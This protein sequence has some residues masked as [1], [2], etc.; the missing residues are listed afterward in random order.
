MAWSA[1]TASST[2]PEATAETL[3]LP[4]TTPP[5]PVAQEALAASQEER[6][7]ADIPYLLRLLLEQAGRPLRGEQLVAAAERSRDGDELHAARQA[8]RAQREKKKAAQAKAAALAALVHLGE[9]YTDRTNPFG[10][11]ST[12]GLHL[13]G[14]GVH[15]P[16][17]ALRALPGLGAR[18]GA[19]D[20]RQSYRAYDFTPCSAFGGQQAA[21]WN[22]F[23]WGTGSPGCGAAG[24]APVAV[25]QRAL[26][27]RLGSD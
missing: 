22:G 26:F 7:A 5:D 24:L 3:P 14:S 12:G 15:G 18:W 2:S 16:V 13:A 23:I 9:E 20:I 10:G 6:G 27:L 4:A 25:S 1:S 11:T 8:E 17:A 19:Q 21:S